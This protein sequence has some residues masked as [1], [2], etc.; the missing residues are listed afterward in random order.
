MYLKTGLKVALAVAF[1]AA[2]PGAFAQKIE[3]L[4]ELTDVRMSHVPSFVYGGLYIAQ[5]KGYFKERGLTV[6]LVIVRG[7]DTTYQVAGKTIE[8]SGGSADSAFFNS[9]KRGLPL[10]LIS[11]LAITGPEH[12]TNPLVVRKDLK[13]SGEVGT[14]AQLKGKKIANL[15][16]GGITEYLLNLAIT[17]GGLTSKDV[18]IVMPM[19]FGQMVEA[20]N[21]KTVDAAM[22]AEPFA[23]MSEQKG[24][25]VRL[26]TTHDRNE[27]IL[28][29]KTSAD[30]AKQNPNIVGNFL[31]AFLKGARDLAGDGFRKPE[32]LAILEKYTKVPQ[33]VIA[34]SMTPVIPVD[35]A[36]NVD[37]IMKQQRFYS[38]RGYITD[39]VILEPA[40]FIDTSYLKSANETLGPAK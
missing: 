30:W 24:T 38:E 29:I 31:I 7:G 11:S 16:P 27:Q 21:T 33:A 35:G 22:L 40:S 34:A 10:T 13:D 19:G 20:L 17:S 25:G 26:G 8:F 15:A 39:K 14:I 23:T 1:M 18:Q 6:D 3:P 32:N 9:I 37:S 12:S 36:L 4:K 28:V 2:A 5:D